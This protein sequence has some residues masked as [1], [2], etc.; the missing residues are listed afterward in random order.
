MDHLEKSDRRIRK[1]EKAIKN[2]LVVLLSRKNISA[3]TV[4]EL[5]DHA[6]I[7]RKTFYNHY[8]SIQDVVDEIICDIADKYFCLLVEAIFFGRKETVL[9]ITKTLRTKKMFFIHLFHAKNNFEIK[10]H[11][12]KILSDKMIS[13]LKEPSPTSDKKDDDLTSYTINHVISG[14]FIVYM[15]W[16]IEDCRIPDSA[17]TDF[18]I[19]I[20]QQGIGNIKKK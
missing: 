11:L 4:K 5:A 3:I 7:N 1:T 10:E 20:T 18:I 12:Y 15:N 9:D 6:D 17:I 16:L 19:E 13:N 14:A 2:T 8:Q